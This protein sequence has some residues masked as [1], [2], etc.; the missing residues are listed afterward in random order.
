[1][2][3]HRSS[4]EI[5]AWFTSGQTVQRRPG[6]TANGAAP[7]DAQL[8][9]DARNGD[10]QA[11]A[12]LY[13][14]HYPAVLA[15]CRNSLREERDDAF[16]IAQETFLRLFGALE[17]LVDPARVGHWLVVAAKNRC[18]DHRRRARFRSQAELDA[19]LAE[20]LADMRVGDDVAGGTVDRIAVR[21]ILEALARSHAAVLSDFYLRDLPLSTIEARRGWA[22]GT[23]KVLLHRARCRA[24]VFA[25]GHYLRGLVA[26]P[27]ARLLRRAAERASQSEMAM[28]AA[29]VGP[30]LVA[31]A[32]AL[33]SAI[34]PVPRIAPRD[35]LPVA[36]HASGGGP[37]S[38]VAAL[39][40]AEASFS[41]LPG[42]GRSAS[43]SAATDPLAGHEGEPMLDG[44]PAT[45]HPLVPF[46]PVDV[47]GTGR[48][49]RSSEPEGQTPRYE[50]GADAGQVAGVPISGAV[51]NYD[52]PE[53][54]DAGYEAACRIVH[55][56][57][58]FAYCR[59]G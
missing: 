3:A 10:Q 52:D 14:R 56:A 37:Q 48:Q 49:V 58:G 13:R 5:S 50:L 30:A 36:P 57:P 26:L 27:I 18:R 8:V 53:Q 35:A 39:M 17:S 1:M 32:V 59:R 12:E 2:S 16:D 28:A 7:T 51:V 20:S 47:P 44:K 42:A 21:A 25:N 33:L 43:L 15:V 46:E 11:F 54:A 24:K 55:G 6:L 19:D 4:S 40:R 29:R 38:S 41:S 34:S 23:G 9:E 22:P 45:P 31:G